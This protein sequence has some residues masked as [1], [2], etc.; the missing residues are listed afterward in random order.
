VGARLRWDALRFY[1]DGLAGGALGGDPVHG[2]EFFEFV[3]CRIVHEFFKNPFE[4][5]V[6]VELVTTDLL[7]EG[8]DDRTPPTGF[9][10]TNEHPVLRAEFCGTD[11]SFGV[12]VVKLDL[13]VEEARFKVRPL[14]AG[15]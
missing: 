10:A 7:D 1:F 13:A 14:V 6:G 9:F 12:V 5:G 2:Q 15:V 8:V 4:V 3:L 11:G